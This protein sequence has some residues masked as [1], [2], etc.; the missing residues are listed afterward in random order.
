[1]LLASE[2]RKQDTLTH[3][4]SGLE[5]QLEYKKAIVIGGTPFPSFRSFYCAN[6][7]KLWTDFFIRGVIDIFSVEYLK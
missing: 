2:L 7:W 5:S 1:L 3:N 4:S 6:V